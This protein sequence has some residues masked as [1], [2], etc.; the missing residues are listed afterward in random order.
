MTI[1]KLNFFIL[2]LHCFHYYFESQCE[3]FSGS[4]NLKEPSRKK[5]VLTQI[6]CPRFYCQWFIPNKCTALQVCLQVEKTPS[7]VFCSNGPHN[8][9]ALPRVGDEWDQLHSRH[10]PLLVAS[11]PSLTSLRSTLIP[12]ED[13]SMLKDVRSCL[14]VPEGWSRENGLNLKEQWCSWKEWEKNTQHLPLGKVERAWT[15]WGAVSHSLWDFSSPTRDQTWGPSREG[16][17]S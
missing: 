11:G 15:F 3:W 2:L 17:M 5:K 6:S 4:P 9:M 8:A 7:P 12:L 16:T 13:S 1:F 10:F 14:L